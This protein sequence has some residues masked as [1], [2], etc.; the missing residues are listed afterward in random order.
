MKAAG[1]IAGALLAILSLAAPA[2][3]ATSRHDQRATMKRMALSV[4]RAD[5]LRN[6]PPIALQVELV[7][8]GS[9]GAAN[10]VRSAMYAAAASGRVPLPTGRVIVRGQYPGYQEP[11][12]VSG[13]FGG[14]VAIWLNMQT[15]GEYGLGRDVILHEIGHLYDRTAMPE[16]AREEF[17]RIMGE[18]R[19]WR[20]PPNSPHEQIAEAYLMAARNT[21]LKEVREGA[22][23][24]LFQPTRQQY[25]QLKGLFK[26]LRRAQT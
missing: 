3:D 25:A 6:G 13:G 17:L 18:A 2:A 15:M 16:W 20:T 14:P 21:P 4:P 12:A 5:T 9:A 19:A 24:Y 22:F 7:D 26:V 23:G 10:A 1:A 11:A 8:E